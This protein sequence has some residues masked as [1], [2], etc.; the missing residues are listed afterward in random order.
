MGVGPH[1]DEDI[2]IGELG[3]HRRFLEANSDVKAVIASYEAE[4]ELKRKMESRGMGPWSKG[5][6]F[7]G[8]YRQYLKL[9][10]HPT[11]LDY[12]MQAADDPVAAE[13]LTE[14]LAKEGLR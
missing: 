7:L 9:G 1:T 8:L 4:L 5:D 12:L 3:T 6:L 13:G 11:A 10:D 2:L 14:A